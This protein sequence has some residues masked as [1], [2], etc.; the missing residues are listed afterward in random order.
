LTSGAGNSTAFLPLE[1]VWIDEDAD[2]VV[3]G[4]TALDGEEFACHSKACAPPPFGTGGSND[5][6]AG[7]A[8]AGVAGGGATG[9]PR[10]AP[11][12]DD[13]RQTLFIGVRKDAKGN[14]VLPG[15]KVQ[16]G[17]GVMSVEGLD[18]N[19]NIVPGSAAF[20]KKLAGAWEELGVTHEQ[21]TANLV[22]TAEQAMGMDPVTGKFDPG[23]LAEAIAISQ[24]YTTQGA[25]LKELSDESG[26]DHDAIVAA[27][28]TMSA[29]RLWDGVANGNFETTVRLVNILKNDS[30]FEMSQGEIDFMAWRA[31]RATK[32]TSKVGLD[33][34]H[35]AGSRL[36]PS[37]MNAAQL[38]ETLYAKNAMR[39]YDSFEA[40]GKDSKMGTKTPRNHTTKDAPEAE[41]PLFT[42]KG[43]N[44]VQ[45]A[46]ALLRGDVTPREGISGPKYS[47]FFSNLRRPDLDYS[48]TNDTWHYRAMAGNLTLNPMKKKDLLGPGTIRELT[49]AEFAKYPD[50]KGGTLVTTAQDHFQAGPAS[51]AE[52]YRGGDGMFRDTT[53]I[54]KTALTT[55]KTRHPE[56]KDMKTHELQALVWVYYGGGVKSNIVRGDNWDRALS[57]LPLDGS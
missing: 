26:V 47:S 34:E 44:Q 19:G 13:E 51:K 8:G 30:E 48:S 52:G 43:T 7:G 25:R 22:H 40:W 35:T 27:A 38:V 24:W 12:S 17:S 31:S 45:Q 49:V 20:E 23:Q 18:E 37:D 2:G 41:Y 15:D 14:P 3:I 50:G 28:T 33:Y 46:V 32:S 54:T 9:V 53:Q 36:K 1:F 21:L 16:H 6:G 56:F 10:G 5:S 4:F 42:S 55:L 39:G 11:L 57:T 29:G